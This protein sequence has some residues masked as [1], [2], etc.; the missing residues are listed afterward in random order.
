MFFQSAFAVLHPES[1]GF[2]KKNNQQICFC[3]F[4]WWPWLTGI[5]RWGKMTFLFC[6]LK[7]FKRHYNQSFNAA[8]KVSFLPPSNHHTI[9]WCSE[10]PFVSLH[11]SPVRLGAFGSKKLLNQLYMD[12]T[13]CL[14]L[15]CL[16][17]VINHSSS[18]GLLC[19]LWQHRVAMLNCHCILFKSSWW[20]NYANNSKWQGRKKT[21]LSCGWWSGRWSLSYSSAPS[22]LNGYLIFRG[23]QGLLSDNGCQRCHIP[24]PMPT[25]SR[26]YDAHAHAC[27]NKQQQQQQPARLGLSGG[28]GGCRGEGAHCVRGPD[29]ALPAS[30]NRITANWT[31]VREERRWW[32]LVG[33]HSSLQLH[34][35]IFRTSHVSC[36]PAAL[37]HIHMS[38]ENHNGELQPAD[39][40]WRGGG[41]KGTLWM[42]VRMTGR[43]AAQSESRKKLTRKS[44]K[45]NRI[46]EARTEERWQRRGNKSSRG[47]RLEG[48]LG[49]ASHLC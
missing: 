48:K 15:F 14:F 20:Q 2:E 43:Q 42:S 6:A 32:W 7:V 18:S 16:S 9:Q 46:F 35:S 33:V 17:S 37:S 24:S 40:D 28:H 1:K 45:W 27:T 29:L 34:L 25:E 5:P 30:D 47:N 13:V 38:L 41:R 39:P 31:W 23:L 12:G 36:C 49:T 3:L 8:T 21:I 19:A 11:C 4:G 10:A 44:E 22:P 26:D